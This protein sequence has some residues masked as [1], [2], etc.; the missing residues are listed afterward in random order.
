MDGDRF[1]LS[2]TD[3]D[4]GRDTATAAPAAVTQKEDEPKFSFSEP[5]RGKANFTPA[6]GTRI[7]K[8]KKYIA[9]IFVIMVSELRLFFPRRQ[10]LSRYKPVPVFR[11]TIWRSTAD[12][13]R[14]PLLG[15]CGNL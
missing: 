7:S 3:S 14:Q 15:F 8:A 5:R 13:S 1:G 11:L 4:F 10:F 12:T 2:I 9:G 6:A